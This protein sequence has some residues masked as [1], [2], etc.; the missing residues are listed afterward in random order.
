[1]TER[2]VLDWLADQPGVVGLGDDCYIVPGPMEDQVFTTDMFI[3]GVHF[4]TGQAPEWIGHNALARGLSDIAAMGADPRFCLVSAAFP[5][6]DE[7]WTR[8]FFQ[9]LLKLARE[10]G[11]VLTGGDLS[12]TDRFVADIMVCGVVPRGL[13]LRRD[14][15]KPGHGVYVSDALGT[16]ARDRFCSL[17]KPRLDLAQSIRGRASACMDLSDGLSIDLHRLC[18]AS[19]VSATLSAVPVAPG[20]T[21]EQALHGGEDYELLIVSPVQIPDTIR[22]GSIVAGTPGVI[23]YRGTVLEPKGYDHFAT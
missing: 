17:V 5:S 11:C 23:S 13:A 16:R 15:A 10:S 6:D 20:A 9:G 2:S 3:E 8:R 22:I 21:E 18:L 12:H 7:A 4:K 14:G 1:M 19:G